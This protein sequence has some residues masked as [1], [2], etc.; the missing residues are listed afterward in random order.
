MEAGNDLL[1]SA[2]TEKIQAILNI[3]NS[4]WSGE[5]ICTKCLSR[6]TELSGLMVSDLKNEHINKVLICFTSCHDIIF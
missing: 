1:L 4:D 6:L 5:T 3:W 2:A